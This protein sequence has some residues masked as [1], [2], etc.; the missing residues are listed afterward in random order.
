MISVLLFSHEKRELTVIGKTGRDF[1]CKL[2]DDDWEFL[3]YNERR[4]VYAYLKENPLIDISCVD[5]ASEGGIVLA[6][7]LRRTNREMYMILLTDLTVSPLSYIRPTIMA[8]SLLMRPL[9]ADGVKRVLTEAATDYFNR[10]RDDVTAVLVV[11]N[12]DGRQPVPYSAIRF[13]ESRD[14]KIYVNTGNREYAFYDT[15]DELEQ[16]L[17]ESFARCHRSFIVAKS[18]IK[19]I[20]I[21]RS[22]IVLDDDSVIPLSR[23][24][25]RVFKELK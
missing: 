13:F 5:V 10:T 3:G 8:G 9:S 17:P 19:N 11:E 15:L 22:M 16:R 6:E 12:R 1:V 24:Y 7:D 20:M 18:H 2:S 23:S 14:K 4:H 25:K 21:S